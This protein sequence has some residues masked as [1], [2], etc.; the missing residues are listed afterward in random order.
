MKMQS[1]ISVINYNVDY[2]TWFPKVLAFFIF[3]FV[4]KGPVGRLHARFS[5]KKVN[6][7]NNSPAIK[8]NI[9][10]PL[11]EGDNN[12]STIEVNVNTP[13]ANDVNNNSVPEAKGTAPS[14]KRQ[15]TD[16]LIDAIVSGALSA[17]VAFLLGQIV[18]S[19]PVPTPTPV[20]SPTPTVTVSPTPTNTIILSGWSDW[21]TDAI[22][23]SSTRQVETRQ[24]NEVIAY[25]SSHAFADDLNWDL[26]DGVLTVSGQGAMPD[27]E[28]EVAPWRAN[29]SKAANVKHIEIESGVTYIGSQCFQYCESAKS[30][31]IPDSVTSIGYAAFYGC[32]KLKEVRMPVKLK[33]D[34]LSVS[35]FDHCTSLRSVVV[36]DGVE[37]IKNAAFNCCDSL[38]WVFI[39][40]SVEKIED[41]AFNHCVSLTD[42][43]Y[44]GS[45]SDWDKIEIAGYNKCL[46]SA[47]FYFDTSLTD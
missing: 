33:D 6:S 44:A 21:T 18:P 1:I 12:N 3:F 35:L 34:E 5:K 43:Y 8:V 27:Y 2:G 36:P 13:S 7:N 17:I 10:S 32:K 11:A 4:F 14:Y 31:Y 28:A 16:S 47:N 23:S 19:P 30:T 39:P 41:S 29:D 26:T 22:Q 45:W 24:K 25:N 42:V 20:P 40:A 15:R 46:T 37:V 38:E 9:H